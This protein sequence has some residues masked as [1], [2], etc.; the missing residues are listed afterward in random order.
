MARTKKIVAKLKECDDLY[1][2]ANCMPFSIFLEM[3]FCVCNGGEGT[4]LKDVL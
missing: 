1:N 4:R 3:L 2:R